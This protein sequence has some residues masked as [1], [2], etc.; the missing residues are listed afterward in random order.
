M[1]LLS[2]LATSLASL[3]QAPLDIESFSLEPAGACAS[4]KR[5]DSSTSL[6]SQGMTGAECVAVVMLTRTADSPPLT[7]IKKDV[8]SIIAGHHLK[9]PAG[10]KLRSVHT[11]AS[12][13]RSTNGIPAFSP[14][15]TL[16]GLCAV[17]AVGLAVLIF[18]V[19]MTTLAEVRTF[20]D[21]LP[22]LDS[23]FKAM[24]GILL[25]QRWRRGG[26]E[27]LIAEADDATAGEHVSDYVAHGLS[28]V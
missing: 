21:T 25:G 24:R 8:W 26:R 16:Y 28:D 5:T 1:K 14:S 3:A 2:S 23:E 9:F 10:M 18:R 7:A 13:V 27:R 6:V 17:F 22:S 20:I 11:I 15:I 12:F 4:A 19:R